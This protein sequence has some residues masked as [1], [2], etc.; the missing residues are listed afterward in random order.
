MLVTF[1]YLNIPFNPGNI[2]LIGDIVM[3]KTDKHKHQQN[4][5]QYAEEGMQNAPYLRRPEGFG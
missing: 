3:H 2:L 4:E 5:Y 1:Q